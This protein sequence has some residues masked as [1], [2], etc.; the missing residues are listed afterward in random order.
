MKYLFSSLIVTSYIALGVFGVFGMHTQANMNMTEHEMPASNCIGATVNGV[1]CPKQADPIDYAAFHIDAFR[2]FSSATFGENIM[3]ALLLL[4]SSLISIGLLFF[5]RGILRLPQPAT[6]A[7]RL[8]ENFSPPQQI[9]L[10]RWLALHEN[11]PA[12]S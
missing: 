12:I 11:S 2:G 10:N 9:K 1:D 5:D 8:K 7:Y 3:A 6:H 4:F